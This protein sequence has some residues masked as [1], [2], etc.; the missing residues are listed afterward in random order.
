M[1]KTRRPPRK[2]AIPCSTTR[3]AGPASSPAPWPSP[4][5]SEAP[6]TRELSTISA[7]AT[8]TVALHG[9]TTSLS[10]T[11]GVKTTIMSIFLPQGKY[12][13]SAAGDLVN[14]GPSDYARCAI[15]VN[16][17]DISASGGTAT[18]VG[19]PN[20][21]HNQGPAS[22][23]STVAVAGGTTVAAAGET[24]TLQCAHDHTNG[25][26]PY[27]DS[28]GSMWAHKTNSLNVGPAN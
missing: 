28:G 27:F 7:T 6:P 4:A 18:L 16:N 19:N 22:L 1:A 26:Q 9:A 21:L 2:G 17:V 24:A 10:T 14:F 23:L 20:L 5:W 15:F 3:S 12:V 13:L 25:S 11:G 8:D